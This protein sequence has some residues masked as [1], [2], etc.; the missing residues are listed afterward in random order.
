M[1]EKLN[2]K[3]GDRVEI[4]ITD[5]RFLIRATRKIDPELVEKFKK[6]AK[7]IGRP[8][9]KAVQSGIP[10]RFPISGME[11]KVIPGRMSWGAVIPAK[12]TEL[13]VDTRMRKKGKSIVSVWVNS[14]ATAMADVAYQLGKR[15]GKLTREYNYSRSAT[16][17]RRHRVNGQGSGMVVALNKA[18]LKSR[19]PSRMVWPSAEKALPAVNAEM[20]TL[21]QQTSSRI[22]AETARNA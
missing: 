9:E 22:N 5:W 1:A 8:V 12:A 15:D 6:N 16:G 3:T 7:R 2:V 21:I 17:K 10:N 20:Y 14:P 18:R 4:A 13:Q 11:P 19:D